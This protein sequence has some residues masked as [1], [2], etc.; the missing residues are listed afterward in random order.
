MTEKEVDDLLLECQFLPTN[1]FPEKK[2]KYESK[3]K[4]QEIDIF[5]PN[6]FQ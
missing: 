5:C 1:H 3:L 2:F 4:S 6:S